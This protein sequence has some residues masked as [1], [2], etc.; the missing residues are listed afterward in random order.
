[1]NNTYKILPRYV[2]DLAVSLKGFYIK[3]E[4]YNRYFDMIFS[5]YIKRDAWSPEMMVEYRNKQ[6]EKALE[7]AS[8]TEYYA[9]LFSDMGAHWTELSSSE[10][11]KK[12]PLTYKENVTQYPHQFMPRLKQKDDKLVST[13][14][15][16]GKSLTFPVS[17]HF[18]S[19]MWAVWWRYRY[20]FGI[21]L[22]TKCALFSSTPIVPYHE[23]KRYWRLNLLSNEY[24]FSGYHISEKTVVNYVNSL[25]KI[26]APWIHGN[27]SAISLLAHLM[28][29]CNLSLNYKVKYVTIGS[30]NLQTWQSTTIKK[31]FGI[32]PVQHYGLMEGTSN[33]S[34]CNFGK[35]HVD[36]DFAF[37][38][39]VSDEKSKSLLIVGTSFHNN[40]FSLIRY[41]TGDVANHEP[42]N[43]TCPCGRPGRLIKN[44]DG[45]ITDYITLPDGKRIATLASPF[46]TTAGLS[47]AQ[48]FQDKNG[49]LTVRYVPSPDWNN[50]NIELIEHKLRERVGT[51]I[52]IFF[53]QVDFVERTPRGKVNL[54][55]SELK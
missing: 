18:D 6:L 44:I 55:I 29:S 36:E 12:I 52:R 38:E 47:E 53:K 25:N 10:N 21:K 30:E 37:T 4:R 46:H 2:Q 11:F 42:S 35:L 48:I 20:R 8:K 16:T 1:M 9:K 7:Q 17:K 45:R 33:I 54:V 3:N 15:T 39:F 32:K 43:I 14:G 22:N 28:I 26:R 51:Q 49:S 24:R 50:K 31:A 13:S 5:D 23:K 19:E 41:V 40:A 27:T 34:E